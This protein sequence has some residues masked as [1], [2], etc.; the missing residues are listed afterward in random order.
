M[1]RFITPICCLVTGLLAGLVASNLFV[2]H[3]DA[4]HAAARDSSLPLITPYS[5]PS[6]YELEPIQQE[7]DL[8]A[9]R[10]AAANH[11]AGLICFLFTKIGPHSY[12]SGI[13]PNIEIGDDLPICGERFVKAYNTETI[14][15][16]NKEKSQQIGAR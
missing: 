8:L 9:V 1:K 12:V 5:V 14:R 11:E 6:G 10:L 3:E 15:L 7:I 4:D 16:R 2:A 13:E